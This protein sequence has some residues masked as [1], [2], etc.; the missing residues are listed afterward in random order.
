M[1]RKGM[2]MDDDKYEQTIIGM[3]FLLERKLYGLFKRYLQSRNEKLMD[4]MR[5]IL[6]D[7]LADD[8]GIGIFNEEEQEY[9]I[10]LANKEYEKFKTEQEIKNKNITQNLS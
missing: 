5:P 3:N 2:T 6:V 1:L 8:A 4:F 9:L 10:T 7:I